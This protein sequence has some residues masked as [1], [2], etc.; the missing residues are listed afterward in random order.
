MSEDSVK[1]EVEFVTFSAGD[2]SFSIEITQVREIRRWSPVTALPHAPNEVLGVM[3]LRGSVIPIY[4]LAARFGLGQTPENP[5]NVIVVAMHGGQTV[6]LL[7]EAVSEILSVS[8]DQIQETPDIRSEMAR[9]SITGVI[10]IETGMTRV[11]DLGAVLHQAG[12][13]LQ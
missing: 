12:R 6:G 2:Q 4:D 7:V 9:Q 1:S 3:N 13:T 5:R 10:P 8:R 11:I